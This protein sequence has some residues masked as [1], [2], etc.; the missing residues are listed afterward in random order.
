M[1][2][3]KIIITTIIIFSLI[4]FT[5]AHYPYYITHKTSISSPIFIDNIHKS[6][7]WY[8]QQNS[9]NSSIWLKFTV[10]ISDQLFL[11]L[12][13]PQLE[14]F[15]NYNPTLKLYYQN[16]TLNQ[17]QKHISYTTNFSKSPILCTSNPQTTIPCL[18]YEPFTNTYSWILIEKHL[19]LKPGT[20]YIQGQSSNEGIMWIAIGEFEDFSDNQ[21][22]NLIFTTSQIKNAHE[23]NNY[24]IFSIIIILSIFLIIY[25]YKITK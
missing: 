13:V 5:F 25:K 14:K 1:K 15:V 17:P 12:G 22:S 18:F 9:P 2:K 20:Y 19:P 10:N 24:I 7:V 8:F 6:Q 11:Q 21:F 4:P 23:N 16:N 3:S